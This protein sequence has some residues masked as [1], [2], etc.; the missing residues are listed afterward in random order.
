MEELLDQPIRRASK[1]AIEEFKQSILWADIKEELLFWLEGFKDEQD[2]IADD[3]IENN[4]STAAV[5][6]HIGDLNGR[7]KAINY[8][9]GILDVFLSEFEMKNEEK[10]N[11]RD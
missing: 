9:L 1:D 3:T 10:E 5:L 7:K 8:L 6:M 2:S 4:K 11:G